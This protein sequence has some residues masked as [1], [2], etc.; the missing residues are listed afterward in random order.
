M[1]RVF[2]GLAAEKVYLDPCRAVAFVTIER[3][4]EQFFFA[5]AERLVC[6]APNYDLYAF[7][8]RIV[9]KVEERRFLRRVFEVVIPVAVEDMVLPAHGY[10]EVEIF[11]VE[12]VILLVFHARIPQPVERGNARLDPL[13]VVYL[14]LV[15]G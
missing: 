6:V 15:V 2:H 1:R 11:P 5:L 14:F 9:H 7:L 10:R 4:D 12:F 3:F 13:V 8:L